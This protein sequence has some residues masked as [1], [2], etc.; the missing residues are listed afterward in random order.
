M[1]VPFETARDI[2]QNEPFPYDSMDRLRL[3]QRPGGLRSM[4]PINVPMAHGGGLAELPVVKAGFGGFLKK[5]APVALA[6]AAPFVLPAIAP[7]VFGAGATMFGGALASGTALGTGA[8]VGLGSGL[9]SLIAGAKPKDALKQMLISG[10]TAGAMKGLTNY[11]GQPTVP[12]TGGNLAQTAGDTSGLLRPEAVSGSGDLI[13]AGA[14]PVTNLAGGLSGSTRGVGLAY[15]VPDATTGLG[16]LSSGTNLANAVAYNPVMPVESGS[17]IQFVGGG[18]QFAPTAAQNTAGALSNIGTTAANT[19]NPINAQG[20][21]G[22]RIGQ[23]LRNLRADIVDKPWSYATK[24]AAIDLGVPDYDL[25]YAQE[26]FDKLSD[27]EKAKRMY[28]EN[29][30][31]YLPATS[32][33]GTMERYKLPNRNPGGQLPKYAYRTVAQGGQVNRNMGGGLLGVATGSRFAGPQEFSGMVPGDGHGMEDNVYM[34]IVDRE[35]GKQVATLAVSPTEYV[36]DSHTMA[37]LGNGNPNEGAK[38]MDQ[39]IKEIRQEA[40]G[41]TKQPNQIDGARSL[42]SLTV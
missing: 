15:G 32:S 5:L 7:T 4:G 13:R 25:M 23:S 37:A 6:I 39:K 17:A 40:Y 18:S 28:G 9:G 2:I 10:V 8:M 19:V 33:F 29:Y 12:T 36:I 42:E 27:E 31:A 22:Q 20:T 14:T 21:M 41:T 3:M 24:A 35:Q 26:E 38:V 34:P 16:Q 1:N 11:F 30:Q